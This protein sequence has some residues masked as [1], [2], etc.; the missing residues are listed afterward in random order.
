MKTYSIL[1]FLFLLS[2]HQ[3]AEAQE[4]ERNHLFVESEPGISIFVREVLSSTTSADEKPPIVLLHGARVPGI[5]SFDLDVPN[6][7]L[8]A[9]LADAGHAVYIM[10]ARGYGQ[11]TR[12]PEMS[13]PAENGRP[14]VRA[15]EILQDIAAV[16]E[17]IQGRR[18]AEQVALL[19]WATGSVWAGYYATIYPQNVSHLIFYNSLYGGSNTHE[20]I[21]HE[22]SLEDPANPGR[23]NY[24]QIGAYRYST[25]ESLFGSWDRSIPV[26]DKTLWRDPA[27]AR[28]Y[29]ITALESDSTSN[30]R[31]PPSFR[32]PSGAMED[33][34]YLA[35]G[36]QLWDASLLRSAVLIIRSE[37]DFWSRTEDAELLEKHL[38]HAAK[39]RRIVIPGATHYVHLD[40]PERGRDQFIREVRSF[41]NTP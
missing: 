40:R 12:L 19:G 14:L 16:V 11:S 26:D 39:V 13:E 1:L 2:F 33:S 4:I 34:F 24:E 36:R 23:F 38:T 32:S 8:A 5:A 41:L 31:T 30:T 27:I 25:A 22:S 10:D 35:T 28:A 21:G 6:G 7:S 37:R 29:A 18:S 3:N 9:D 20:V 15:P 17:K